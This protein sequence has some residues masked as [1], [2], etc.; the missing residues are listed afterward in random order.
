MGRGIRR[1]DKAGRRWR[2]EENERR[3]YSILTRSGML[4]MR[5]ESVNPINRVC[6]CMCGGSEDI[7]L[8]VCVVFC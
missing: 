7:F 2:E 4:Q 5:R 8:F 3:S 6:T 1:K